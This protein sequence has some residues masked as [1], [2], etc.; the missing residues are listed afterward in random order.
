[1]LVIH[2]LKNVGFLSKLQST[3]L[4]REL[5]KIVEVEGS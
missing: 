5:L 3:V 1:M 4:L 2:R